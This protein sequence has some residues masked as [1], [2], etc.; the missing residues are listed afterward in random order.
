M[1]MRVNSKENQ[2]GCEPLNLKN[3][4]SVNSNKFDATDLRF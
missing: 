3:G 1:E 4:S 2:S